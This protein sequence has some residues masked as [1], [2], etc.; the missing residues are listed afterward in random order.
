MHVCR[1]SI[2]DIQKKFHDHLLGEEKALKLR[3][4]DSCHEKKV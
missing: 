4:L 2:F 3:S 1:M